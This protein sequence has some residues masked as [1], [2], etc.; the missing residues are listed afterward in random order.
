MI[1]NLNEL[2]NK[3]GDPIALIDNWRDEFIGYA[4]W[5]FEETLIWNVHH[6]NRLLRHPHLQI[7]HQMKP[8]T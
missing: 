7:L 1:N 6:Q 8:I 3:Y 4:V 2:I 5:D